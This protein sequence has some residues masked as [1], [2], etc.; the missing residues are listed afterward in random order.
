MSSNITS[1]S[2]WLSCR[3]ASLALAEPPH[4]RHDMEHDQVEAAV[5]RVRD[6]AFGVERG[7]TRLAHRRQVK[8]AGRLAPMLAPLQMAPDA[9]DRHEDP[10]A[11]RRGVDT[12]RQRAHGWRGLASGGDFHGASGAGTRTGGVQT[13][14]E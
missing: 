9:P 10:L 1:K 4:H 14:T 8:T 13:R 5:Q 6:A 11:Y 12:P 2:D 7:V 3:P